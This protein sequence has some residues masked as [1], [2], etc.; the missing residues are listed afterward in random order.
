M[1]VNWVL[2]VL[3]NVVEHKRLHVY[4]LA[5]YFVERIC[6]DKTGISGTLLSCSIVVDYS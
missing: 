4:F 1:C 5:L 2:S 6:N 3:H